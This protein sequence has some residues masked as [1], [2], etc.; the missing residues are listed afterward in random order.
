ADPRRVRSAGRRV[1]ERA[2]R[3]GGRTPR[4]G[5]RYPGRHRLARARSRRAARGTPLLGLECASQATGTR[6]SAIRQRRGGASK[7]ASSGV[8]GEL[9]LSGGGGGGAAEASGT[10]STEG[11]VG[12]RSSP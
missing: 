9:P 5:P 11:S 4:D 3:Y 6:K 7:P 10:R 8:R 12:E 1:P 2:Q